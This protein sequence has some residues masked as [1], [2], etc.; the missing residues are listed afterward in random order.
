MEI[1]YRQSAGLRA[2]MRAIGLT[3]QGN[4]FFIP[5]NY[6]IYFSLAMPIMRVYRII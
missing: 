2:A 4:K 6:V 3:R 5:A 1:G